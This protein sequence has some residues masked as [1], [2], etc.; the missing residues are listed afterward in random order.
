M[1]SKTYLQLKID[2]LER[3]IEQNSGNIQEMKRE[4]DRLKLIEF[5]ESIRDADDRQLLQE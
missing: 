4:L 3:K 5:E 2:E 1:I